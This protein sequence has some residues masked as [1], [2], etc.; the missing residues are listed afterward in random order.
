MWVPR[1]PNAPAG[2][3]PRPSASP[4]SQAPS[5]AYPARVG[6]AQDGPGLSTDALVGQAHPG[7]GKMSNH[8]RKQH[9]KIKTNF[10][11]S[12]LKAFWTLLDFDQMPIFD[13]LHT[14]IDK[15]LWIIT[16]SILLSFWVRMFQRWPEF[17]KCILANVF[18]PTE[19]NEHCKKHI[20]IL[21]NA[22]S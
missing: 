11:I 22:D 9:M 17:W 1:F 21:L 18:S 14:E 15:L 7:W 16:Q 3:I 12:H 13:C 20:C 6:P 10:L 8:F 2:A 4:H 19:V 5:W